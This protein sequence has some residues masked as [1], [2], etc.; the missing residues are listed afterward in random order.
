MKESLLI[1]H[2]QRINKFI[3]RVDYVYLTICL[4]AFDMSFAL[5]VSAP[6][7]IGLCPNLVLELIREIVGSGKLI[8]A[9]IAELNPSLDQ[10][11]KTSKLASK[12]AYEIITDFQS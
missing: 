10:D 4:D 1:N 5:G 2:I 3:E 8:S 6:S 7:A 11:N 12:L 9:D